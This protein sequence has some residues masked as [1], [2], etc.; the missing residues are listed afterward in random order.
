[1]DRVRLDPQQKLMHGS[2]TAGHTTKILFKV[3]SERKQKF[4][5]YA[6]P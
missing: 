4:D 6:N 1:M 2:G 3:K 5:F